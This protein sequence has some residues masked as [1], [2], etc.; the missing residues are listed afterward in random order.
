MEMLVH[1]FVVISLYCFSWLCLYTLAAIFLLGQAVSSLWLQVVFTIVPVQFQ[2][3]SL[4]IGPLLEELGNMYFA[5]LLLF[6][7][8]C[9]D[10]KSPLH[11]QLECSKKRESE[12]VSSEECGGCST[13]HAII[14]K[15]L[16]VSCMCVCVSVAEEGKC[17]TY[18]IFFFACV[19]IHVECVVL[20]FI[21]VEWT[22]DAQ[23]HA[24][25]NDWHARH[26]GT[27]WPSS[28]MTMP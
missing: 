25:Q 28:G 16:C 19:H 5:S 22:I 26:T 10:I 17:A 2:T 11:C 20:C 9:E 12:M 7:S 4:G 21:L 23:L 8:H 13:C 18:Q 3:V 27:N 1:K 14:K 24:C 15:V 6:C